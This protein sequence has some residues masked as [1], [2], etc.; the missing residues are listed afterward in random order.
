MGGG[1]LGTKKSHTVAILEI[2]IARERHAREGSKDK[3]R[4]NK[5]K[6]EGGFSNQ[7]G[8]HKHVNREDIT[9]NRSEKV[10]SY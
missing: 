4:P 1:R 8:R 6:R 10:T 2:D 7:R 9:S 3:K 5:S